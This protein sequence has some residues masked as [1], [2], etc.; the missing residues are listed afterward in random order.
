MRT[1]A[2]CLAACC[3]LACSPS[4]AQE[5]TKTRVPVPVTGAFA[6][7]GQPTPAAAPLH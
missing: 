1:P 6:E 2:V 4:A 7:A 3:I 5:P